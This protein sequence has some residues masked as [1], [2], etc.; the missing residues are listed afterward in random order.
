MYSVEHATIEKSRISFE[1]DRTFLFA[2]DA[3]LNPPTEWVKSLL[4]I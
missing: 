3:L 2:I 4:D 1:L